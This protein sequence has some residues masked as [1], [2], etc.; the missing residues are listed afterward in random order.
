M[1]T[2]LYW[3]SVSPLCDQARFDRLA[4]SVWPAR[5][6]KLQKLRFDGARRLSLGVALLLQKALLD[7]GLWSDALV[8]GTHGKLFFAD[9]PD[10]HFS[11]SHSGERVLCAVSDADIGCDLERLHSFDLHVAERFFHPTEAAYLVSLPEEQRTEAF[12]RLWTGK[13]SFMK[14][15]GLGFALPMKDFAIVPDGDRATVAQSYD[16]RDYCLRYVALDDYIC[17]LCTVG[18]YN[19]CTLIPVDFIRK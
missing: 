9:L 19:D 12:F 14:A 10:F 11:F 3:A 15:T 18:A 1:S 8:E 13:E 6:E 5:Q 2:K 7:A 4:A 16:D 17:A